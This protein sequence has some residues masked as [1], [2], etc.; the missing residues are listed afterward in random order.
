LRELSQ[1]C[2]AYKLNNEMNLFNAREIIAA[3]YNNNPNRKKTAKII[4]GRD[5]FKLS[6]DVKPVPKRMTYE[7]AIKLDNL[8]HGKQ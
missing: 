4:E 5:I 1:R 2:D 8:R 6:F 3:I 7:D